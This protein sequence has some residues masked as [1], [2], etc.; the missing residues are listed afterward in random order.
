LALVFISHSNRDNAVAGEFKAW[1]ASN[2]FPNTFLDFDKHTGIDIGENWE[3]RLYKEIEEAAAV[4]LVLTPAWLDSKWCFAEF[5]QARAL[6]KPIF[7]VIVSP[8]GERFI[9]SDIQS[10]DLTKEWEGGLEKLGRSLI[11]VAQSSPAGFTWDSTRVP[12]PGLHAF[13][14]EDAASFFGRN[15]EIRRIIERLNLRRLRGGP[16]LIAILGASGVGKSSLL[17]AGIIPRLKRDT[18]NWI[19]LPP[20]RP[21]QQPVDELAKSLAVKVGNLAQWQSWRQMLFDPQCAVALRSIAQDLQAKA[22]EPNAQVLL[23][24]DQAEELFTVADTAQSRRLFELVSAAVSSGLPW[25]VLLTMRSDYLDALQRADG[26]SEPFDEIALR[27]LP[28]ERF[29]EIIRGPAELAKLKVEDAFVNAAMRDAATPDV[30]PL[31]AFTLRELYDQLGDSKILSLAAYKSLGDATLDL[32]PLENAVRRAADEALADAKPTDAELEALRHAFVP[33]MV[34]VNEQGEYVRRTA[35]L[36][37]LP[38]ASLRLIDAL[39]GARLLMVR[40]EGDEKLI[41][42]GHEALLRKWPRARQ[43]LDAQREFLIGRGTLERSLLDWKEAPPERKR[44]ALLRGLQLTRAKLWLEGHRNSLSE[45]EIHFI[46]ESADEAERDA[47]HR[48]LMRKA[49]TLG[50]AAS[51][52]IFAVLSAIAGLQWRRSE[53]N[54]ALSNHNLGL[55]LLTEAQREFKQDMPARAFLTAAAATGIATPE[56]HPS[57]APLL[58][59]GTL[60]YLKAR[61]IAEISSGAARFPDW[62]APEPGGV[63]ALALQPSGNLIA[64]AGQTL[65]V[66]VARADAPTVISRMVGHKNRINALRFSPDGRILATASSDRTIGIWDIAAK[67]ASALCAQAGPI[68]SIAFHPDGK[69]LASASRD[70]TIAIWDVADGAKVTGFDDC[71]GRAQAVDFSH[72]GKLLAYADKGGHIFVRETGSWRLVHKLEM[73]EA[74]VVS[75]SIAPDAT[76]L[77]GAGFNGS[78]GVFDLTSG[79]RVGGPAGHND[80]LWKIA[81]SPDGLSIATASWD[82]TVRLWD[83]RTFALR[84]T[85][86]AHD[87][88]VN[89]VAFATDGSRMATASEDG[90]VRLFQTVMASIQNSRSDH[91]QEILRAAFSADGQRMVTGGADNQAILYALDANG[92]FQ[93]A[94]SPIIHPDWVWGVALSADG[95]LAATSGTAAGLS[96]NLVQVHETTTCALVRAIDVGSFQINS[97]KLSPDGKL[98]AASSPQGAVHIWRL[99]DGAL[100]NALRGHSGAVIDVDFD[101]SGTFVA[102]AGKDQQ[103]IIWRVADGTILKLLQGFDGPVWRVKFSPDGALLATGGG[104]RAIRIWN[105]K[106]GVELPLGVLTPTSLAGLLFTTDGRSLIVGDDDRSISVWNT[107]TWKREAVLATGVGVR[108]PLAVLPG[109]NLL[110]YDGEKGVLRFW[111]LGAKADASDASKYHFMLQGTAIRF[112]KTPEPVSAS[113][114][115]IESVVI[116]PCP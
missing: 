73:P 54:R 9:A 10:L 60:E 6:G 71:E 18:R 74:D 64:F 20:I 39:I 23:S 99:E 77:A 95:R 110:A 30:L 86:D 82:G 66:S 24:I 32:T 107:K 92:D 2:G 87:H 103:V 22:G 44:D 106:S 48:I 57:N 37:Q 67:K 12:F 34:R 25:L 53:A 109:S 90:N 105:W 43:W 55:A 16:R 111:N 1:L 96:N 100:I 52:L 114:D 46:S 21:H 51:A 15:D 98:L 84:S 29:G 42:F 27:P 62:M 112:T 47:R 40:Q 7:P 72:D 68:E 14:E 5:A 41:E 28:I 94:C 108:G 83:S 78:I 59:T 79:A 115:G 31:L 17:R 101:P 49:L 11:D 88:W 26:L 80:K 104:E 58:A 19:V 85:F 91:T 89:D 33:A 76:H 65:A 102:S 116:S 13:E 61:T 113:P 3:R 56:G 36:N 8:I 97:L 93:R 35:R 45:D 69:W 38:P 81:Y 50:A 70:R 75:I 4:L 63:H